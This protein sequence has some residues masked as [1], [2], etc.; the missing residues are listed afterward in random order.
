MRISVA[1]QAS[2]PLEIEMAIAALDPLVDA[3]NLMTYDYAVSDITG[4]VNLSPNAP[5]YTPAAAGAIAMSVNYTV[6]NYLAA[7][8]EPSKLSVGIALYGHTFFAPSVG[9]AWAGF[10][11]PASNGGTCCGPL[12][13]TM[14]GQPGRITSQCGTYMYSEVVTA[15]AGNMTF[16]EET[17]SDIAYFPSLGSDG[18]TPA[19]TWVS[20][21]G[22]KSAAAIAQYAVDNKLGGVFIFDSSMDTRDNGAWTYNLT[23]HIADTIGAPG[24][25]GVRGEN[26]RV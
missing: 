1:S 12:K 6:S 25:R 20:Y 7:G 21:T 13:A 9:G 22:P 18:Y 17:Q 23:N 5:L 24:G 4:A 14:G 3:F 15:G 10:G 19:G 2:K 11:A 26:G 8:I 16:D